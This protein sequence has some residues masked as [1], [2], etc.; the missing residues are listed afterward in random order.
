[1]HFRF[2]RIEIVGFKIP[3]VYLSDS[4][5]ARQRRPTDNFKYLR[6]GFLPGTTGGLVSAGK[7]M[8]D[9]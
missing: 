5:A 4:W 1:L 9:D 2:H 6:L 3:S 8:L 7:L